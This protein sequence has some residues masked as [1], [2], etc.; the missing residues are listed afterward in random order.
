[1]KI[2][3]L[4]PIAI[5]CLASWAPRIMTSGDAF[6]G[7]IAAGPTKPC[8][9]KHKPHDCSGPPSCGSIP[10]TEATNNAAEKLFRLGIHDNVNHCNAENHDCSG[11]AIPGNGFCKP[12]PIVTE[13]LSTEL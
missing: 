11:S 8:T 3:D 7:A 2:R 4:A 12:E 13:E 10:T 6:G 9:L 1:M 5:V